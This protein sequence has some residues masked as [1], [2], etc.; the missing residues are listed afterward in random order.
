MR[1]ELLDEGKTLQQI[2]NREGV[3]RQMIHKLTG[4]LD[5]RKNRSARSAVGFK[6]RRG[7]KRQRSAEEILEFAKYWY[8]KYHHLAAFDWFPSEAIEHGQPE[9]AERF[10][11][12]GAP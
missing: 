10:Y 8:A 7:P 4:N 6:H 5:R 3:S 1:R 2:A 11:R 9:R 12:E